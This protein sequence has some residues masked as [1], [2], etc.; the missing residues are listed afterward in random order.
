MGFG[1][2]GTGIDLVGLVLTSGMS[3]KHHPTIITNDEADDDDSI[4]QE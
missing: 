2:A 1:D 3:A 4:D